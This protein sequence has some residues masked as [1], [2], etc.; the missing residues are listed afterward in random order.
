MFYTLT[1]SIGVE[2]VIES[3]SLV[4][5]A[6]ITPVILKHQSISKS[7]AELIRT[8]IPGLHPQSF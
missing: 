8:L 4:P 5:S 3:G 6:L 2:L 7:L 1:A